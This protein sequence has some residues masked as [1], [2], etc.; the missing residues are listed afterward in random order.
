MQNAFQMT[1]SVYM[2][3]G[4]FL[5]RYSHL[6]IFYVSIWLCVLAEEYCIA[7]FGHKHSESIAEAIHGSYRYQQISKR[8]I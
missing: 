6:D 2:L 7:Y 3:E 8:H 4:I 1:V 5:Y